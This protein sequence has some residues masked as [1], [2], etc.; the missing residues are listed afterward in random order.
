MKKLII[1]ALASVALVA[2]SHA[3]SFTWST[4]SKLFSLDAT[5]MPTIEAGKSYSSATTGN[6]NTIANQLASY[7]FTYTLILDNGGT[8]DTLTGTF[9]AGDFASRALNKVLESDIVVAGADVSYEAYF[10]TVA[11]GQTL[12]SATVSGNVHFNDQGDLG[13]QIAQPATWSTAAAPEP[14]SGLML[15]LGVGLMALKRKRA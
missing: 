14:T 15:L 6:A 12:T 2:T 8:K 1:T 10:S 3:A 7:N 11:N 5:V 9:V 13:L 4:A